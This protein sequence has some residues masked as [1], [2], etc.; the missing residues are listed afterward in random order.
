[1]DGDWA[2]FTR[3]VRGRGG[4]WEGRRLNP[5]PP[6]WGVNRCQK[7]KKNEIEKVCAVNK[8][9]KRPLK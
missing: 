1:M 7:L 8:G 2:G 3:V 4:E 6:Q 5:L 9:Q